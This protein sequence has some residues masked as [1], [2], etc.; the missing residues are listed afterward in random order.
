L[1]QGTLGS[2]PSR[3]WQS[4]AGII[5]ALVTSAGKL[6]GAGRGRAVV[7]ALRWASVTDDVQEH[8]RLMHSDECEAFEI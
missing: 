5:S 4:D 2:R 7:S 3:K 8:E 1:L 6:V